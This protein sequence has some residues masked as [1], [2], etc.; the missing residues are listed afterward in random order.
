MKQRTIPEIAAY[1]LQNDNYIMLT[2][3][4][5]DGDT[6]GCAAALCGGLRALGKTAAVW[7]NPQFTAKFRPYL[8]GLTTDAIPEDAIIIVVD[9]AAAHL[10]PY[11][12]EDYVNRID[13]RLDHHGRDMDFALAGFVDPS[14]AACGEIILDLLEQ[15][16]APVDKRIAEAL[17]CAIATDTG[18]FRYSNV[19]AKTLRAA[20]RCKDCGADTFAVNQV[21]F[22]TKRLARLQ[23]D[24][25]LT[26]TTEF[27][28]GGKVAISQIPDAVIAQFG[29]TEDDIDDISGFGRE[30]EGVKI[31]VM[32]R[33][34]REGGKISVRTAPEYDAA[35]IC[36]V[37]GG[38]GHRAAA[39]ATVPGGIAEA[40][41]AV[42]RA[43]KA[44]GVEL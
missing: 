30:I 22:L 18:C 38:G 12:V 25:F 32:L 36:A 13:L 34:T 14:A 43:L 41:A 33:E 31:G 10:L 39:G 42:L 27:L 37:L 40:R 1:L 28:S 11:G 6:I 35:A 17:Y 2:H 20:A 4:R 19:T 44:N 24:A 16:N 9:I 15:M 21:M 3:R 5:P 26:Q 8:D 23:L 29:V 7:E